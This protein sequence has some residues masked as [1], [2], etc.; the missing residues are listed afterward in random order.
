MSE[1]TNRAAYLKGLADGL[2]L[3]AE[4]TEGKLL[5][6]IITLLGDMAQDIEDLDEEQA[7]I[8]DRIDELE[9]IVDVIGDDVFGDDYDDEDVYT[10]V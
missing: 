3:D 8:E 5:N 10:L 6:E 7:F 1:I 2:K 4:T 9:E